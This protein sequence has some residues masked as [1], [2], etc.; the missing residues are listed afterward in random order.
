M[1]TV[2]DILER[3]GH[4]V[5]AIGPDAT[6]LDAAHRMNNERIGSLVVIDAGRVA[7]I[8]TERD[9]MSRIVA[10]ERDPATTPVRAIMTPNPLSCTPADRVDQCSQMMSER[11]IR[12]LPVIVEGELVGIVTISDLLH[13]DLLEHRSAIGELREYLESPPTPSGG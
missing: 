7:G 3:K 8:V 11:H 6:A 12:R 4:R 9:I 13:Q 2:K 1:A 5:S 10:Q